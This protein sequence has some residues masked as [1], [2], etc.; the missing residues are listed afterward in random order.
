MNTYSIKNEFGFTRYNYSGD[1]LDIFREFVYI[2]KGRQI[3]TV[4]SL[5][6]GHSIVKTN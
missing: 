1:S 6:P 5:L 4:I 3:V 2:K